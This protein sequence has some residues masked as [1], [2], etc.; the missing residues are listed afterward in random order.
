[1]DTPLVRGAKIKRMTQEQDYNVLYALVKF[2]YT[3]S[4]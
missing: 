4:G 1:M 2:Y 3:F